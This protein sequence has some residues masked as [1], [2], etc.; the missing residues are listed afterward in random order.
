MRINNKNKNAKNYK[1]ALRKK[2]NV[3]SWINGTK[4]NS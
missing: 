4:G 2:I 3:V 1:N